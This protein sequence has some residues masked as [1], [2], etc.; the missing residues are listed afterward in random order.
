MKPQISIAQ[1][2]CI[3][4]GAPLTVLALY[5]ATVALFL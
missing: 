5:I 3:L 4:I 2:A 1:A